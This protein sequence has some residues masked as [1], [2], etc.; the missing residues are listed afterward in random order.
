MSGVPKGSVLGPLLSLIYINGKANSA[1]Q[2]KFYLF[3]DETHMLYADK[4]FKSLETIV[5]FELCNIHDWLTANKL[6]LNI[7]KSNFVLFQPQTK[8]TKL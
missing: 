7:N 4:N 5:N 8:E 3:A 6:S 2:L 1:D